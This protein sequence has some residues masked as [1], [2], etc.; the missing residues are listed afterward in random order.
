M[1]E[2]NFICPICKVDLSTLITDDD[3]DKVCDVIL[4][5]DT[6][7]MYHESCLKNQKSSTINCKEE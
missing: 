1:S 6:N 4:D 2:I 7:Q 3:S 5:P